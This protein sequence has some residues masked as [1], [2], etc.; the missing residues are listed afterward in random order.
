[1]NK[2]VRNNAGLF[3]TI[4]LFKTLFPQNLQRGRFSSAIKM[5]NKISTREGRKKLTECSQCCVWM[6]PLPGVPGT[7]PSEPKPGAASQCQLPGKVQRAGVPTEARVRTTRSTGLREAGN[8]VTVTTCVSA[9]SAWERG[10][11]HE[12]HRLEQY[13]Q[14]QGGRLWPKRQVWKHPGQQLLASFRG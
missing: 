6:P 11:E 3:N 13:S 4:E 7:E 14:K 12:G 9:D 10:E 8:E 1:M 5:S 2:S